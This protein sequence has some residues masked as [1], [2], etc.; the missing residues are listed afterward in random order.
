[1]KTQGDHA[2][3]QDLD[4][5]E[6]SCQPATFSVKKVS[7]TSPTARREDSGQIDVVRHGPLEGV[8]DE[9][10]I[11]MEL[12]KLNVYGKDSFKAYGDT[13]RDQTMFG[14]PVVIFPTL[15]MAANLSFHEVRMVTSGHC[16]S[17]LQFV[18]CPAMSMPA[19]HNPTP[20]YAF[21]KLVTNDRVLP[22]GEYLG[23]GLRRQYS[24]KD[25][26]HGTRF[27]NYLKD[28]DVALG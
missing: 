18:F 4:K 8:D 13:L 6:V 12:H 16:C 23:I 20:A 14:P 26:T 22:D 1:M 9:R 11:K 28:P 24:V 25:G 7:T 27:C 19:P 2:T 5:L 17:D 10:E 15:M 21:S 3:L